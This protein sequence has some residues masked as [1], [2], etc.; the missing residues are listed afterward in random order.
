MDDWGA[1]PFVIVKGQRHTKK[2]FIEDGFSSQTSVGKS[3]SGYLND[4]L[5]MEYIKHF[6]NATN[7][8]RAGKWRL[9]LFD[10]LSSHKNST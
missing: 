10:G 2:E 1:P 5:M 8:R 4:E 3:E 7:N 9:L 6:D